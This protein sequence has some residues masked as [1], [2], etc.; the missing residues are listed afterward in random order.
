MRTKHGYAVDE[1]ASAVQKCIRR[2]L[3]E[4]ALYWGYEMMAS[5]NPSHRTQLWNRLKVIASE[6][7]GP[8]CP[9][10]PILIDVLFRNWQAKK[11]EHL[12]AVNAITALV[13]TQKSRVNDNAIGMLVSWDVLGKWDNKPLPL[14]SLDET[15]LEPVVVPVY[16]K[17]NIPSFAMDKHTRAGKAI[18]L[19]RADFYANG[20]LLH[21]EAP[22]PDPYKERA[23]AGGL[24]REKLEEAEREEES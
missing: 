13:R 18:G 24:E 1:V 14:D 9:W 11:A 19:G 15:K 21:N 10:M 5:P 8:A 2:G 6:D 20:A 22:I 17:R 4:D 12:F 3:E 16:D 7:V 23:M